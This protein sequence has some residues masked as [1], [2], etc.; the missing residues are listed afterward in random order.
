[1]NVETIDHQQM[2]ACLESEGVILTKIKRCVFVDQNPLLR[3]L[4]RRTLPIVMLVLNDCQKRIHL[5][6]LLLERMED[7]VQRAECKPHMEV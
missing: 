1:M 3:P 7:H 5:E 6:K 2:K 4:W